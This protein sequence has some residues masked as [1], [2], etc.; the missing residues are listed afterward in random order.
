MAAGLRILILGAGGFVGRALVSDLAARFGAQAQIMPRSRSGEGGFPGLDLCDAAGLRA[1]LRALRPSH[2][3]NLAGI[4]APVQARRAP[5]EAW[6]VHAIAVETLGRIMLE[7]L[8]ESWL[9]HVGSGLAYGKAALSGPVSED[10][11]LAPMDPYGVTKAAGDLALGA[12]ANEGL[13]CLRLRPFNHT[14][15]GQS[16]DF[17]IPAFAAQIARI[18]AGQ[19]APVLK[20]GNLEAVRDFLDMRDV[21]RCYGELIARSGDLRP[22]EALNIASGVG[23]RIGDALDLLVAQSAAPITIEADPARQRPSDL[24]QIIG[25]P[26]RIK[27]RIG[28]ALR[29]PHAQMLADT[30]AHF[31]ARHR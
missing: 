30:L 18:E 3:V 21:L 2:I 19:Q 28:F 29:I 8:P 6:A 27:A 31:R 20:V 4:A 14:G 17:A 24:P 7:D 23:L 26:A 15:P 22:G 12:L 25:N 5:Q 10:A 1:A 9:L 16:E 11:P 13:R